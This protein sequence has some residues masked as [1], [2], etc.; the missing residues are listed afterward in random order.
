MLDPLFADLDAG[1]KI[2][3]LLF[4]R[5]D[6]RV[7]ARVHLQEHPH[8]RLRS[9]PINRQGLCARH[10][11]HSCRRKFGSSAKRYTSLTVERMRRSRSLRVRPCVAPTLTQL[12]AR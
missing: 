1:G 4:V 11:A 6:E 7:D 9:R 5:R 3:H 12:A 8:H 10:H 2:A